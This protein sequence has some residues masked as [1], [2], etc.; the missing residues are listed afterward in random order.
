MHTNVSYDITNPQTKHLKLV[1]DISI[2]E[3]IRPLRY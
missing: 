2:D 3:V 1:A